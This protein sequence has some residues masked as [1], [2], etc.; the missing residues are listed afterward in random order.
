MLNQIRRCADLRIHHFH[1][2]AVQEHIRYRK[3]NVYLLCAGAYTASDFHMIGAYPGKM[4]RWG[5][6][7]ETRI[8]SRNAAVLQRCLPAPSSQAI[9]HRFPLSLCGT[10]IH[11][12]RD[13]AHR[14]A[15]QHRLPTPSSPVLLPSASSA[16]SSNLDGGD[17]VLYPAG[18]V[19]GLEEK[20]IEIFA[21]E[22]I[23]EKYSDNARRH[24]RETHDADQN[25]YKMIRIYQ[26]IIG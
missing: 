12:H 5:Y 21:K 25:Y 8:Y 11:P 16:Q 18:S 2:A 23:T 9:Q 6:F 4:F 1:T 14:G 17:G 19:E 22:A 7:P 20:L 3:Q 15:L 10:H 13:S 24:A 26:E